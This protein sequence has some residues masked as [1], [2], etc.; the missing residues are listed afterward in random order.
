MD[1]VFSVANGLALAGWVALMVAAFLP[2]ARPYVWPA[3]GIGLP[4]L[5]GLVYA[6]LLLGNWAA[7]EGGGFGSLAEVRALFQVPALL[8]AG[9]LHYLAFDL[10][11]GTWIARDG[12]ARGLPQ[13]ALV[14]CFLLTFLAGPI[15][16]LLYLG[17]RAFRPQP[18]A[19]EARS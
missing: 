17:L 9:W 7:A 1:I 15:G 18:A 2:L 19:G 4:V 11:V 12:T 10:F 13:A 8:T 14:P 6:V 5:F 3:T 16:L